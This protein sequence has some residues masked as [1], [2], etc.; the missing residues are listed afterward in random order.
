MSYLYFIDQ[1]GKISVR[2]NTIVL[3]NRDGDSKSVPIEVIEGIFVF[4]NVNITTPLIQE[5][6][7]RDIPVTF[8]STTGKYFGKL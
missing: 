1:G 8:L 3:E 2:K 5:V 7:R 4:G 6:L